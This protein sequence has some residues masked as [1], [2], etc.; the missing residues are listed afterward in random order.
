[1]PH[2][3]GV[4]R[5]CERDHMNE[6]EESKLTTS[7][8]FRKYT[9]AG[10]VLRSTKMKTYCHELRQIMELPV[11]MRMFSSSVHCILSYRIV[12]NDLKHFPVKINRRFR[13]IGSSS[14]LIY[15]RVQSP[16]YPLKFFSVQSGGL[17]FRAGELSSLDFCGRV[18]GK[19]SIHPILH[20]FR[21]EHY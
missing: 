5:N 21:E 13:S 18:E 3:S 8:F 10:R 9:T 14:L 11:E 7:G 4:K 15:S 19:D 6:F 20:L 2:G 12:S 17:L 16:V 1:M